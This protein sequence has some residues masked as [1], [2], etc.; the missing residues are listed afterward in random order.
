VGFDGLKI[1]HASTMTLVPFLALQNS[2][3]SLNTSSVAFATE[4][5]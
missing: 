3:L 2:K 4:S 1:R 5:G